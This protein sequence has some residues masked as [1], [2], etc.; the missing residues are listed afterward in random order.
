[1][2]KLLK[3]VLIIIVG[4]FLIK[5]LFK[6]LVGMVSL[7]FTLIVLGFLIYFAFKIITG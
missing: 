1:M 6:A 5:F 4:Y 2:I 3:L 7:F